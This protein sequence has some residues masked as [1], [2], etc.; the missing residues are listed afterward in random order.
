MAEFSEDRMVDEFGPAD[1]PGWV[2]RARARHAARR[3]V[4]R[5]GRREGT[6]TH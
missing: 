2:W 1:G 6:T 4:L 5:L 3:A